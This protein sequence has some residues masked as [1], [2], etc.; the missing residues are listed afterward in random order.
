MFLTVA[1]FSKR[2]GISKKKVYDDWGK[3]LKN[4]T[5]IENGTKMIDEEAI[6]IYRSTVEAS[7]QKEG[8]QEEQTNNTQ[9][10]DKEKQTITSETKSPEKKT[11]NE[12]LI[13][14]LREIIRA[15]ETEI[16]ELKEQAEEAQKRIDA[17]D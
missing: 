2:A 16:K 10:A 1:E 9:G 7:A 12:I 3:K 4:Y 11:D 17:K 8:P 5:K 15:K 6:K 14:E 13:E